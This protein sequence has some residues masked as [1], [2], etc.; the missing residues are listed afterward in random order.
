MI[1]SG[2]KKD[3]LY[4]GDYDNRGIPTNQPGFNGMIEGILKT[5]H[6]G[7]M[8]FI[9]KKGVFHKWEVSQSGWSTR[10]KTSRNRYV[11]KTIINKPGPIVS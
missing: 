1:S 6:L 7:F 9:W 5:A 2:M 3:P 10:K 4:I 11:D 8:T